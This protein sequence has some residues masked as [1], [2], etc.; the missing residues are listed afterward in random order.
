MAALGFLQL[1]C[2]RIISVYPTELI[3]EIFLFDDLFSLRLKLNKRA[4]G[5][6]SS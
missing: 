2:A 5:E 1:M 3:T 6:N 4:K